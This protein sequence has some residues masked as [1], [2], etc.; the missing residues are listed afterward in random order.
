MLSSLVM[1]V[2]RSIIFRSLLLAA[3]LALFA[4]PGAWAD[5]T[6]STSTNWSGYV[7]HGNGANFRTVTALWTQPKANCTADP[8]TYSAVWVGLGGYSLSSQALEQIG[9]EADCNAAGREVS[10]AWYELVPAASTGIRMRVNPGDVMAGRVTVLGH[11]VTLALSDRT[12]HKSFTKTMTVSSLD[13]TSADWI[14]EAPS[15]CDGNGN[16]CQSLPLADF[17]SETFAR[18]RAVTKSGKSGSIVSSLWRTNAIT[19]VPGGTG[20][21]YTSYS[22]AT[23]GQSAPSILSA[24][25]TSFKLT[26]TPVT[27][28][29]VTPQPV[30]PAQPAFG[31]KIASSARLPARLQPGGPRR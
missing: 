12:R 10:N 15:Q 18:A 11:L 19:L 4:V 30:T 21:Q 24:S 13:V 1:S 29:P 8:T 14:V 23:Q 7:A 9:T 6:T 17:G 22:N 20:P 31:A 25:G 27:P 28:Q 3:A 5:T 26:Y 16:Q 2:S